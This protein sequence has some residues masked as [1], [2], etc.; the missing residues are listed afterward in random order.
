MEKPNQTSFGGG[1]EEAG[2]SALQA[3]LSFVHVM[4]GG[5]VH[6]APAGYVGS[7]EGLHPTHDLQLGLLVCLLFWVLLYML[8]ILRQ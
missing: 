2:V 5:V 7:R 4:G 8:W 3:F 1:M 6:Q